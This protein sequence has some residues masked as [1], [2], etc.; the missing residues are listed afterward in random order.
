MLDIIKQ[1]LPDYAKDIKLNLGQV[2]SEEGAAELSLAQIQ[3]I[4]LASALAAKQPDLI[5][6]LLSEVSLDEA[7]INAAYAANAIMAMNNVYY[8]FVHLVQDKE[9]A[10]MPAK[11]RMNV[12]GNPGI[13]KTDFE[14][15]ALAI[16]AI[17]GCGMCME[18]HTKQLLQ[19]GVSRV[20]IQS[21]IR[22]AAV[23]QA[24]ASVLTSKR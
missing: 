1:Q 16:S 12:I 21:A 19:H 13:A 22:L 10:S 11:L 23:M 14:L 20:S 9:L 3:G 18:S 4:A 7:H 5:Q 24:T 8:R 15:Y 2:L 17:N 6:A